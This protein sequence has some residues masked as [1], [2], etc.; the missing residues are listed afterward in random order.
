MKNMSEQTPQVYHV[1]AY[2]FEGRNRAEQ[3]I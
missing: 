2:Q 3:V 1:I